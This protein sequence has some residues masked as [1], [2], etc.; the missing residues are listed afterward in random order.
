MKR[1]IKILVIG[2]M[3]G[4][5]IAA[6]YCAAYPL[7]EWWRAAKFIKIVAQLRS[8]V[9][10]ESQ[11]RE[12]LRS[13]R[14]EAEQLI[15]THWDFASNR[16]I[17]ATGYGYLFADRRFSSFHRSRPAELSASLFF[18]DGVLALKMVSLQKKSGTCCVVLVKEADNA[19]D[20]S[21]RGGGSISVEKRGDPVSEIIVNLRPDAS[22]EDRRKSYRFNLGCLSSISRCDDADSLFRGL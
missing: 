9:T 19:F 4:C 7:Y 14:P 2:L 11:A 6:C 1:V 10:T 16:A 20:D 15:T 17:K 21:P 3:A 5:T 18:R 8:G 22:D 13:Y 12:A